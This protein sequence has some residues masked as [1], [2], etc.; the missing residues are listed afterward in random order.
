MIYRLDEQT[1]QILAGNVLLIICCLFYLAWWLLAFK[2]TGAVK[3]MKSGWLLLPAFVF[4]LAGIAEIVRG[5]EPLKLQTGLMP[6]SFILVG[7]IAAYLILYGLTSVA[8]KRQVTTELFLI[9]GWAVL[10]FSELNALYAEEHFSKFTDVVFIIITAAAVAV[11]LICYILY[12][13]LDS[14]LGYYDGAIPLI[15]AAVIP[16]VISIV[17]II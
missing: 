1:K 12:Y 9:V 7:G 16:A 11:S 3:G 17:V 5:N 15:L 10:M 14:T 6:G 2:P 4:G 13:K 8:L